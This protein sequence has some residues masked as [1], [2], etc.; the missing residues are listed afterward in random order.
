MTTIRHV[1]VINEGG[2]LVG[3]FAASPR[4]NRAGSGAPVAQLRAGP[5]QQEHEIDVEW[6]TEAGG[7]DLTGHSTMAQERPYDYGSLLQIPPSCARLL[8]RVRVHGR[9]TDE[10]SRLPRRSA[11]ALRASAQVRRTSN[12][13]RRQKG[14]ASVISIDCNAKRPCCGM[15]ESGRAMSLSTQNRYTECVVVVAYA[16]HADTQF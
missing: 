9:P 16:R 15:S 7:R 10:G 3:V 4:Q 1:R 14:T 8:R 5:G 2:R 13:A 6:P 11:R 12:E